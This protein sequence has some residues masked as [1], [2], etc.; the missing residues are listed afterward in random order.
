MMALAR[1]ARKDRRVKVN[2]EDIRAA[3]DFVSSSPAGDHSAVLEKSTGRIYWHSEF[4]DFDEIPEAV[5]D[6]DDAIEREWCET[7]GVELAE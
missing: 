5:L 2:F 4:G 1:G 6:S 3:F 7:H